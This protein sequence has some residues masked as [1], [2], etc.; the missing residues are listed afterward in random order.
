MP[1]IRSSHSSMSTKTTR[2]LL[3]RCQLISL[4]VSTV[5]SIVCRVHQIAPVV[6]SMST[7]EVSVTVCVKVARKMGLIECQCILSRQVWRRLSRRS[8]VF[9]TM[10]ALI[11]RF[12]RVRSTIEGTSLQRRPQQRREVIRLRSSGRSSVASQS[13]V[14][15]R[16]E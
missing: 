7:V 13:S 3:T 8:V 2:P 15:R 14:N 10:T 4:M 12:S 6:D 5:R 11:T 1:T 9:D 16:L